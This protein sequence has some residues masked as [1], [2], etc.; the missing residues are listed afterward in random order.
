MMTDHAVLGDLIRI[1]R[2]AASPRECRDLPYVGLEHIEKDA[3]VLVQEYRRLPET[4][5]ATKFRFTPRH[6][7]YG[8]LRP[9]LNKVLLPSF[10]GVCT[11]EILP[12]LPNCSVLDAEYLYFLLQT[13]H[14]VKWATHNVS[15]A[16]LPRLDPKTLEE[17]RFRL[18]PI[19]DQKRI[20]DELN[21]TDRL[22]RIWRYALQICDEFAPAAFL[23]IFG[24]LPSNAKGWDTVALADLIVSGPQNGLY[25]PAS[26]YGSGTPI[27]RID[28]FHDGRLANARALK[29]LQLSKV[30]VATYLL[31]LND[32]V[33]NRVNSRPYLGK[34]LLIPR[35]PE[36]TVFKSNMMRFGVHRDRV[37]PTF[38]AHQLQTPFV[39]NQIQLA[40]KDAVNQASINQEDVGSFQIRVPS[41]LLQDQFKKIVK[42]H[43]RLRAIHVEALRQAD[44]LFQTLLYQAFSA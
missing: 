33:I 8:K 14:F 3:G 38:L 9:Y 43:E 41:L 13:P 26:S 42:R 21:R 36:P 5:L 39:K 30:E 7:L 17:Y 20:A 32:I 25:K 23:E 27:L 12:L 40:A 22:R 11:T 34:A 37:N 10:D 44:H 19:L 2:A 31:N 28:A 35:L 1:D 24:D 16:N 4:L 18:P 6:V 29:R 15:G